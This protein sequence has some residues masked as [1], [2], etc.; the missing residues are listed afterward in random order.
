MVRLTRWARRAVPA[1]PNRQEDAVH[2]KSTWR[3]GL[4][5]FLVIVIVALVLLPGLACADEE[6]RMPLAHLRLDS[7]GLDNSGPVHIEATQSKSG[8]TDLRVSAFGKIQIATPAELAA[9]DGR[10]INSI[11]ITYSRGYT[12]G[13]GRN[14]YVLLCQGFS[15][16]IRVVA[17][18]TITELKGIRISAVRHSEP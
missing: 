2:M 1:R 17:V 15:S 7:K 5:A 4:E 9:L 14:I 8:L 6:G 16:G 3:W 12:A 11:G 10:I 18:V 13:G